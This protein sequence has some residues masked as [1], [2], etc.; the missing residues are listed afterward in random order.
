VA[1]FVE[2]AASAVKP[3]PLAMT[4][5]LASATTM[6]V[7]MTFMMQSFPALAWA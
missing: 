2:A 6:R 5:E 4:A 7:R 3:R 1:G